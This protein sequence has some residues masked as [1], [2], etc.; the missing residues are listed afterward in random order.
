MRKWAES[1]R[2]RH[3]G[4][5]LAI[6]VVIGLSQAGMAGDRPVELSFWSSS[7]PQ[8]IEFAKAVVERWNSTHPRVRVKLQ[9]L[10]ASRSTEEVLL[11][12]IAARSTP[13]ICANIY[14]GAVSQFVES[15]GLYQVDRLPGFGS[16]MRRRLPS[17][18]LE[19][20]RS[21]DGHYYQ[22]PWKGNPV[23]LGYNV[24][25]L[26]EAGIAPDSLA[27]YRG[28]LNAARKLTRD[29][30]GDGRIDR[31]MICLN[32][33]PIW[34]QRFFDFYC[35]YIAASGGRTLLAGNKAD[36]RRPEGRQVMQ[37]LA[38]LFKNGYA[39]RSTFSGDV[40]LQG[41]AATVITGPYAIPFYESM[42]PAGFAYDFLPLPVPD[43]FRGN[44]VFTFSDPKNIGIFATTKHPAEAWEFVKFIISA[45]NDADFIAMTW[46]IPY[47]KDLT[48][49]RRSA[50]LLKE[51]PLLA[52][53]IRQGAATRGVDNV[54]RLVEVLDA[55][56]QEY[57]YCA[58]LGQGSAEEAIQ[59][60]AD[61]V[62]EI[63]GSDF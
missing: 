8:E 58:V 1:G 3:I 49:D 22:I 11:A 62:D 14:P 25:L 19:Q 32:I 6:P 17:G 45:E 53:F 50:V 54:G 31:W 5:V 18:V 39:P 60:A 43:G 13:D 52:K 34:W 26:E 7:N 33:E 61:K 63:L 44:R 29:T 16:I 51:R 2:C 4:L 30:N 35:L 27:T 42:K 37:F 24:N 23:M 56:A 57:Q 28:F 21:A 38:D 10:P 40:F 47:R 36:F 12:A 46:Q 55:I 48:T 41:K 9:P 20:F 15:G 59:N